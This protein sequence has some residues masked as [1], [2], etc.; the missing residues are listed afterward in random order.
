MLLCDV[1]N[2]N[3]LS[4]LASETAKER[5]SVQEVGGAC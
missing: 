2:H 5:A 1:S 4:H 3:I